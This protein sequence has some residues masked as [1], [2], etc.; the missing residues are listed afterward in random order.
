MEIRTSWNGDYTIPTRDSYCASFLK[1]LPGF[2]VSAGGTYRVIVA[3]WLIMFGIQE[4]QSLGLCYLF[5][6]PVWLSELQTIKN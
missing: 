4:L 2:A 3:L 1:Q 6:Y 5:C